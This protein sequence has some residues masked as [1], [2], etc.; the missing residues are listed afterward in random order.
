MKYI[1]TVGEKE[2]LIEIVDKSHITVNGQVVVVDFDS[3]HDQPVFSLLAD[4]KSFE[5]FVYPGEEMLEVLL[6]GRQYPVKVE[7]EREKRL[8]AAGGSSIAKTGEY[9]MKAPMPGM[10]VSI[11]VKEGQ[12]VKKGQVLIILESM[13][14]QNELK[15]PCGGIVNRIRIQPGDSVEQKQI[16]L[17][18]T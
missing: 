10:V 2:Y 15:V 18:V 3:I 6:M 1:T 9:L 8:R 13:K 14:M 17:S 5:G 16:L 7:D 4:G 12:K 11:Q